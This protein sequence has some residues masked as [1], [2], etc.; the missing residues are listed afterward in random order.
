[1]NEDEAETL[2]EEEGLSGHWAERRRRRNTP[3]WEGKKRGKMKEVRRQG[4]GGHLRRRGLRGGS[5]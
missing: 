1:M 3:G 2:E 5:Y 4:E